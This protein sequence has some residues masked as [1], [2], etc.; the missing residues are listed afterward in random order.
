MPFYL[1]KMLDYN[2]TMPVHCI[3]LFFYTLM[4][5]TTPNISNVSLDISLQ[6]NLYYLPCHDCKSYCCHKTKLPCKFHISFCIKLLSQKQSYLYKI[7]QYLVI[8]LTYL[9]ISKLVLFFTSNFN[10]SSCFC[11]ITMSF[12]QHIL[13]SQISNIF[14]TTHFYDVTLTTHHVFTNLSCHFNN[15]SCFYKLTFAMSF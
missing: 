8:F 5:T 13:L 1:L 15:S 7:S 10:N 11:Y 9:V 6:E 14:L 3:S 2:I 12:K 4:T